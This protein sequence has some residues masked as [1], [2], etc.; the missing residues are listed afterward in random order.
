MLTTLPIL[1]FLIFILSSFL[2]QYYASPGIPILIR[3]LTIISFWLGFMGIVL[4]PIDLSR[5]QFTYYSGNDEDFDDGHIEN[6][7]IEANSTYIPWLIT[8][9]STFILA[10]VILPF[11]RE[12]LFSGYFTLYARIK[13]AAKLS[14]TNYIINFVALIIC[15]AVLAIYLKSVHLV[16]ILMAI[17]NT[18]GLLLVAL[19]LG[20]GLVDV[21]R[22][23]WRKSMPESELRRSHIMAG[24]ADEALFEAVWELQV[25][26]F[27][28]LFFTLTILD[29]ELTF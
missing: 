5:T 12:V 18:Y 23:M 24:A 28:S 25:S 22:T 20:Y 3:F 9:W 27:N 17:G 1:T 14:L 10:W 26:F 13:M 29:F 7:T 16:P 11:V 21:P 6:Q 8:Y 4:L 2:V 15:I 19:L